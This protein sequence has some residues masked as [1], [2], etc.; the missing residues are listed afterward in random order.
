M[1]R[2]TASG[3]RVQNTS[4]SPSSLLSHIFVIAVLPPSMRATGGSEQSS[5]L[6]LV[7]T[8]FLSGDHSVEMRL[9]ISM[10]NSSVCSS[11][12]LC[13]ADSEWLSEVASALRLLD[14]RIAHAFAFKNAIHAVINPSSSSM[15]KDAASQFLEQT[16]GSCLLQL[17]RATNSD[18][19][20]FTVP[21]SSISAVSLV[22][23]VSSELQA[24]FP[25]YLSK[26]TFASKIDDTHIGVILLSQ[27]G[28]LITIDT[29]VLPEQDSS[30]AND[31]YVVDLPSNLAMLLFPDEGD[32]SPPVLEALPPVVK[33]WIRNV[34]S[35]CERS[36]S[37]AAFRCAHQIACL[38]PETIDSVGMLKVLGLAQCI[39]IDI[40]FADLLSV[41][42]KTATSL[43]GSVSLF[44]SLSPEHIQRVEHAIADAISDHRA[45][46]AMLSFCSATSANGVYAMNI[47]QQPPSLL[48]R[49]NSTLSSNSSSLAIDTSLVDDSP[50]P[51]P[52][53][54]NATL[55]AP[56]DPSE[57]LI[58][59]TFGA[60]P[61]M[62]NN[63][64]H[65][66][67]ENDLMF[68][69]IGQLTADGITSS[70]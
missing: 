69:R 40:T 65:Q 62:A 3:F 16:S 29:V 53:S 28:D 17:S 36:L 66:S 57:S 60:G 68:V 33:E 43:F 63:Q 12:S 41:N 50:S 27:S 47:K 51:A 22:D 42:E 8:C 20:V 56:L 46:D 44:Q 9:S 4:L 6:A 7:S 64:S 61:E 67:L 52:L 30:D 13:D 15:S 45:T 24:R 34:L 70:H 23:A 10:W 39:S 5:S 55:S 26:R 11:V 2:E 31:S 21:H 25:A 59:S 49:R 19:L 18:R 35:V 32:R 1:S 37:N 58:L 54:L 14:E 48:M 38:A